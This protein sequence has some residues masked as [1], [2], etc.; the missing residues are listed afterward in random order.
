MPPIHFI[1]DTHFFHSNII[2]YCH[3]PYLDINEMNNDIIKKWNSVV[4]KGDVVWHLGDFAFFKK[5]ESYKITKIMSK[6]NGTIN[7]LLGN[8]DKQVSTDIKFWQ[9][10]GFH[11]VWDKPFLFMDKYIL[12]HEPIITKN[13][14]D[15]SNQDV[16]KNIH[17]H[18]HNSNA[19]YYAMKP[20]DQ[21][22]WNSEHPEFR[23]IPDIT[24]YSF[25]V[26]MEVIDYKPILFND[27]VEKMNQQ[28]V[29]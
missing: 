13:K 10:L 14:I 17:G 24:H 3:R 22:K 4:K 7:L 26:S 19:D 25:N 1:S 5:R 18:T 20:E 28:G 6:L 21:M 2:K 12:S 29:N 15:L 9:S 8:H 27:I 23:T 11:K 16:L